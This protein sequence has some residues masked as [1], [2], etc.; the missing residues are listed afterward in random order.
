MSFMKHW[1][2]KRGYPMHH[3]HPIRF[4]NILKINALLTRLRATGSFF[5]GLTALGVFFIGR[6]MIAKLMIKKMKID[7]LD[8]K[9]LNIRKMN[10][11]SK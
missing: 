4:I 5:A 8:I 7:T 2:C 11:E 9:N 6:L 3:H 1:K 10:M